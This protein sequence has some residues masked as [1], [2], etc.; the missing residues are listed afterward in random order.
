MIGRSSSTCIGCRHVRG[1]NEAVS[2][3]YNITSDMKLM[4]RGNMM[5]NVLVK[6]THQLLHI[7]PAE[8]GGGA[9]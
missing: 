9:A 2:E 3:R 8:V 4:E 7:V 5:R 6:V 1:S